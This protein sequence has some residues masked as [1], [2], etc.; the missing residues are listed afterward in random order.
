MLAELRRARAVARERAWAARGEWTDGELPGSRVA[1][2]TIEHAVIDLDATLVEAHSDKADA[3]PHYKGGFG[4]HP[5]L[6]HLDNT[7]EYQNDDTR[8]AGGERIWDALARRHANM[9]F[10]LSGHCTNAGL[11]VDRGDHG[12]VVYG[13]QADYQTYS[14]ANVNENSYLRTMQ[15]QPEAG[16]VVVKTY[17]PYCDQTGQ[18]PAFKT[19]SR[20]QFTLTGVTFAEAS[21]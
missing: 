14:V 9:Q 12:N 7:H 13:I 19:D 16:T 6:V 5:L 10:V 2:R 21:S 4:F 11:H 15:I 8:T 3:A 17:S 20:N 1:D 18:C